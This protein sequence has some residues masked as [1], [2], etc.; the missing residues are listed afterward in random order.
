M[1]DTPKK[2]SSWLP[3]PSTLS[4]L[5]SL[6]QAMLDQTVMELPNP[7]IHAG[8]TN[9]DNNCLYYGQAIKASNR[10]NFRKAM[11]VEL[12]V[13]IDRGHWVKMPH[14]DLPNDVK[15]IKTSGH[16]NANATPTDCCSSTKPT[17]AFTV[18][19]KKKESTSGK[20][21]HPLCDGLPYDSC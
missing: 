9:V 8:T 6:H 18:A 4:T 12:K 5:V 11:L 21:I 13:H 1:G 10:D 15:S 20:H 14:M 16:S 17:C 19:C 3:H 2:A 7:M